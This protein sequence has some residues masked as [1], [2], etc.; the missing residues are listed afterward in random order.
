MKPDFMLKHFLLLLVATFTAITPASGKER[1]YLGPENSGAASGGANWLTGANGAG[2]T[3][4]DFDDAATGGFDFTLSNSV[5]GP[6]NNADWRCPPFSLGPAA[7]GARP[8]VF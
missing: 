5:A 2:F 1:I 8:I 4:V 6:D 7:G 3:S